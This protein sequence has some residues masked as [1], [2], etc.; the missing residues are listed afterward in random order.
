[1]ERNSVEIIDA[2]ARWYR[3]GYCGDEGEWDDEEDEE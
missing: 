3:E 2:I 1:M